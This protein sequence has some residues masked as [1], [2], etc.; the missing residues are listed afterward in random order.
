MTQTLATRILTTFVLAAAFAA[1]AP[2]PAAGQPLSVSVLIG[3]A[4]ELDDRADEL[5]DKARD[6][7]EEGRYDRAVMEL[8]RLI[9]LKSNRTDAAPYGKDYCPMRLGQRA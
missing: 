7:I 2:L 1:A 5:Y 8:D 3:A 4:S 9:A 6:L